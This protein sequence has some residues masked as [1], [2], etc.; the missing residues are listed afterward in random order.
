MKKIIALV[1]IL[2]PICAMAA[3]TT[4][5]PPPMQPRVSIF[6]TTT[7]WA[8]LTGLPLRQFVGDFSWSN[9][10]V[11]RGM[12]L[13]Y[14]DAFPCYGEADSVR[15]WL[16]PNKQSDGKLRLVCVHAPEK[17]SFAWRTATRDADQAQSTGILTCPV[18]GEYELKIDISKCVRGPEWKEYK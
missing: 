7:D 4:P 11:M 17:I 13:Y 12:V 16:G 8:A 18:T 10:D 15:I 3:D 6:S 2:M 1:A 5:P 14:L 9:S